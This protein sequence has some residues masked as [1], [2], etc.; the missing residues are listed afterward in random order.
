M[1]WFIR[2]SLW[3]IRHAENRERGREQTGQY[4]GSPLYIPLPYS[5]IY[6]YYRV[7]PD[8]RVYDWP[9]FERKEG[10]CGS[11]PWRRQYR[12]GILTVGW[13]AA[14][15]RYRGGDPRG[16]PPPLG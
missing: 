4:G 11:Q 6:P 7:Y 9:G 8:I 1:K 15:E 16:Q 14:T 12:E 5:V 3:T 2:E 10:D 13:V